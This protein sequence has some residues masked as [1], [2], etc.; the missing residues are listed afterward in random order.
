MLTILVITLL[1]RIKFLNKIGF[2]GPIY[3]LED[4]RGFYL[5]EFISTFKKV[6]TSQNAENLI[7]KCKNL[8]GMLRN[9]FISG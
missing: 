1:K 7:F 4:F 5:M 2:V 9:D 3:N 6:N 8:V